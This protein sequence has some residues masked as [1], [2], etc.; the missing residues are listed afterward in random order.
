MG[1]SLIADNWSL[2]NIAELLVDGPRDDIAE[3]IKI[4]KAAGTH[5]LEPLPA[6]AVSFEALFDLITDIVLRDQLLVDSKFTSIWK[7]VS[8]DLDKLVE[9]GVVRPFEFLAQPEK[10]DGPREEFIRR[11][12]FTKSIEV[13]HERN[14]KEWNR[15][16][17]V[18]DPL[19]SSTLW[20]GA[21]MLARA[22]TSEKGYTPHP[23]R[24]RLFQQANIVLGV[25]DAASNLVGVIREKRA[26]L[27]NSVFGSD[28]LYA[29][30]L[31]LPPIPMLVIREAK[32]A[33]QIFPIAVQMRN[34]FQE[35]RDWIK[36]YQIAISASDFSQRTRFE[37]V[38]RSISTYIDSKK[39]GQPDPNAPTF[40]AGISALKIGLR[41]NP[42]ETLRNQFGVR[43]TANRLI[44]SGSG[45]QELHRLLQFF[46]HRNSAVSVRLVEHFRTKD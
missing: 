33:S 8:S 13:L 9:N 3:A 14:T 45:L 16:R 20:G 7:T 36:Q 31:S 38:I 5:S 32:D 44:L 11:L 35:L 41:A 28:S 37:K 25:E 39:T 10:L 34:E 4:D 46:G 24:R 27:S 42:I 15:V 17:E 18:S 30:R 26:S 22:F 43:A 2:Q 23:L 19:I 21:G 40:T 6:A 12:C 29:L 1:G